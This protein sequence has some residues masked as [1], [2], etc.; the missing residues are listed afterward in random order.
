[1]LPVERSDDILPDY[2]RTA[3]GALLAAQ[4]LGEKPRVG[5][6][7]TL[8]IVTCMDHRVLL[9]V[10]SGF[11]F[12]IRTAG[13]NPRPVLANL[14]FAVAV[15]GVGE[16]AVIGHTDCAMCR[17]PEVEREFITKLQRKHGWS[18]DEASSAFEIIRED[19]AIT[20]PSTAAVEQ[21]QW[22]G[23]W[24]PDCLVAPL[25]YDVTTRRL[26]QIAS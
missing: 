26:A 16:I 3:V 17:A 9:D 24:F 22:L 25:L 11:A 18:D 8:A 14:A 15:A 1:M 23:D 21:A 4:N 2:R 19:F 20:D 10:P 7:P 13:A 5:S 12:Q 6:A